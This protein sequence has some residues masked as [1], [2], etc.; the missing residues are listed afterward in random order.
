MRLIKDIKETELT[1]EKQQAE[2]NSEEDEENQDEEDNEAIFNKIMS[3][4]IEKSGLVK[5]TK[6]ADL[7]HV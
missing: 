3:D 1:L 5:R 6:Q 4:K 2:S 7:S